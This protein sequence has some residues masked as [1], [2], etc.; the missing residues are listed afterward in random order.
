MTQNSGAEFVEPF[1]LI[2]NPASDA[3]LVQ[4]E[5]IYKT[6]QFLDQ[7]WLIDGRVL[8]VDVSC[9]GAEVVDMAVYATVFELLELLVRRDA[10]AAVA[11]LDELGEGELLALGL[12][13]ADSIG[14]S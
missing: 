14:Q 2:F 10:R 8:A 5:D 12:A 9:L 7:T 3:K 6:C 11:A 13:L 1:Y 4:V